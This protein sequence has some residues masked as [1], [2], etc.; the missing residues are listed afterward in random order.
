ML[1]LLPAAPQA[2]ALLVRESNRLIALRAAEP[3]AVA[4]LKAG[5]RVDARLG[6]EKRRPCSL[7]VGGHRATARVALRRHLPASR[8]RLSEQIGLLLT[9][10]PRLRTRRCQLRS[11]SSAFA[12]SVWERTRQALLGKQNAAAAHM[13]PDSSQGDK[14]QLLVASAHHFGAW[15]NSNL[16]SMLA[17]AV[18]ATTRDVAPP[19]NAAEDEGDIWQQAAMANRC[20]L[21]SPDAPQLKLTGYLSAQA[22]R[23]P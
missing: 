23:L 10:V 6:L 18:E 13:P 11:V 9:G 12:D 16:F 3:P 22:H 1:L 5:P 19:Y 7:Q 4:S 14:Q 8:C 21:L 20:E 2:A 15:Q 17:V